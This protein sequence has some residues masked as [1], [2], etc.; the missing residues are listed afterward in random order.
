[1]SPV[2]KVDEW[3]VKHYIFVKSSSRQDDS[4]EADERSHFSRT[5][6]A[7]AAADASLMAGKHH[8]KGET[9]TAGT[10]TMDLVS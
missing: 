8:T 10:T 9:R 4:G 1:M 2:L 7:L 5:T 6:S 3:S